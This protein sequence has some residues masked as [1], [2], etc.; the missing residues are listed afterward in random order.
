SEEELQSRRYGKFVNNGGQVYCE[1]DENGNVITP[2][3]VPHEWYEKISIDPG[4]KNPLSAHWYATDFDGN[5]FVVA[6][7]YEAGKSVEYHSN[8]IKNICERLGWQ[9]GFNGKI[10]ALIDSAAGQRTLNGTKS[11]VEL[12][13]DFGINCNTKVNKDLFSGINRV[14]SFLKNAQGESKLYIFKNCVNLI[15]EIKGYF[16]GNDDLPTKKDDHALDELRYYIMTKQNIKPIK[17]EK[18]IIQK[19]KEMLF[20]KIKGRNYL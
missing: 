15:R 18:S 1:F 11:V 9:K 3:D 8:A 7:H 14:K 4:L 20:R 5:V 12:F 2:F 16:W 17:P 13:F 6:E 19:N 10:D